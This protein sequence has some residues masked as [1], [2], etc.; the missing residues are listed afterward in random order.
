MKRFKYNYILKILF[1]CIVCV[2]MFFSSACTPGTNSEDE[3]VRVSLIFS[4]HFVMEDGYEQSI[5]IKKGDSAIFKIIVRE[6][7]R[8][9]EVSHDDADVIYGNMSKVTIRLPSVSFSTRINLTFTAD[10]PLSVLYNANGGDYLQASEPY[11]QITYLGGHP[12]PNAAIGTDK[13]KKS[14][15]TLVGW[16]TKADGSGDA[17][18]LGSRFD[19]VDGIVLYA[20][21]VKWTNLSLFTFEQA[22][23]GVTVKSYSGNEQ[24]LCI[25]EEVDGQPVVSISTNAF[26]GATATKVILP[27]TMQRIEN[28]AFKNCELQELYF[29]DNLSYV[30]DT[31]FVECNNLST[32]HINAIE[33]PRYAGYDRHSNYAD[34]ADILKSYQSDKKIVIFGGSGAY[35]SI[36]SSM[37]HAAFNGEYEIVNMAINAWYPGWAQADVILNFLNEGDILLHIPEM[38]SPQQL[39][40][41]TTFYAVSAAGMVDDR[42]M[43]SF[44]ENY[45]LLALV[46]IKKVS[47]VFD[48]FTRFNE[49]RKKMP[50]GSYVD[51]AD[52]I[53]EY[54]D[55][56]QPKPA[57]GKDVSI[58]GEAHIRTDILTDESLARLDEFY[59]QVRL[60]GATAYIAYAAVNEH[61]LMARD[62]QY[63]TN[64]LSLAQDFDAKLR[65]GIKNAMVIQ[66]IQQSFFA[67]SLFYNSDWHLSN[68][69]TTLN[70]QNIIAC[71]KDI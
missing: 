1:A 65:N 61:S 19:H 11:Q 45:D 8:L 44:E 17:I 24:I 6:G 28:G 51:Y 63:E 41:D 42:Y 49:A 57:H 66:N 21:W 47:G 39:F 38:A 70:T 26:N 13:M 14:G 16:N 36:D 35:F 58:S 10:T 43:A 62:K 50:I 20:Q 34:K 68:E 64:Y 71:L 33:P 48:S 69:G 5:N 56:N 67:G 40:Y 60:R 12:R 18:G 37:L 7:Y 15:H 54:G 4:E 9:K 31:A 23:G 59:N 52:F 22:T 53:D 3:Y 27:K 25:P 2:C 29:Y 46:D 55:Y 32:L 30:Y